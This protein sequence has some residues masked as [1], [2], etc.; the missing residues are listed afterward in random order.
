MV[1]AVLHTF[2]H[3]A[4]GS[5]SRAAA[6]PPQK[7]SGSCYAAVEV[8]ALP[9]RRSRASMDPNTKFPEDETDPAKMKKLLAA[10][11][12]GQED[13]FEQ[14]RRARF[15]PNHLK[16]LAVIAD[17]G[18]LDDGG[19][20]VLASLAKSR[21]AELVRAARERKPGEGALLPSDYAA[22]ARAIQR[23][24]RVQVVGSHK[25]PRLE[26]PAVVDADELL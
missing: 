10:M 22:A 3:P 7:C 8:R 24:G 14:A 23:R 20:V 12:P 13:R 5:G 18:P 19:A 21:V 26:G 6:T 4:R 17:R 16:K 25:K 15:K 1:R 9:L 11:S 2:Q